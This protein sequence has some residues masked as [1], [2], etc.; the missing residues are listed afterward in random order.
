MDNEQQDI[1]VAEPAKPE[2]SEEQTFASKSNR[3]KYWVIGGVIFVWAIAVL[4]VYLMK[5]L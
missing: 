3:L 1:K 4:G 5:N 2:A